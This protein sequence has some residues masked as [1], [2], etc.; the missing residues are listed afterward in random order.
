MSSVV[1]DVVLHVHC[2]DYVCFGGLWCAQHH[3]H[4]QQQ[5]SCSSSINCGQ[6][7]GGGG[8]KAQKGNKTPQN[9]IS[10]LVDCYF[11]HLGYL[12]RV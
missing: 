10:T 7:R 11:L 8:E 12:G 1:H 2:K 4:Q 3:H 5:A 6:I 9:L